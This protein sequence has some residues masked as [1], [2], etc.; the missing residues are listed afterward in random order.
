MTGIKCFFLILLWFITTIWDAAAWYTW[1]D[2][3]EKRSITQLVIAVI[4]FMI[5]II[6]F[7]L[8]IYAIVK[9]W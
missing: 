5:G 2:G 6:V 1:C 9:V 7:M 3:L 4:L 8:G